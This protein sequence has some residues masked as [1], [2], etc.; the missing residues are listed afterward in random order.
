M[1]T[2]DLPQLF[3]LLFLFGNPGGVLLPPMFLLLWCRRRRLQ[4]RQNLLEKCVPSR[5]FLQDLQGESFA[6]IGSLERPIGL[7]KQVLRDS[8]LRAGQ[9]DRLH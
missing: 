6:L 7:K 9:P 5:L 1:R 3:A 2:H 4:L 8:R